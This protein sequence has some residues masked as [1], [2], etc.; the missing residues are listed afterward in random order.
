MEISIDDDYISLSMAKYIAT[1]LKLLD[2]EGLKM[3]ST[4]ITKEISSKSE[5]LDYAKRKKFMTAV[6]CLGWLSLCT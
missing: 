5:P 6:G 2:F 3:D 1:T 4:P